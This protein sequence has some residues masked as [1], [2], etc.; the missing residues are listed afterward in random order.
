MFKM[1]YEANSHN[2]NC[3]IP[4]CRPLVN[5]KEM[6][7]LDDCTVKHKSIT[8]TELM[9]DAVNAAFNVIDP[10]CCL[11]S[12]VLIICGGGNNGG[13]GYALASLLLKS[14]VNIYIYSVA[15]KISSDDTMLYRN[16]ALDNDVIELTYDELCLNLSSMSLVIDA[17][18]G[19]GF[20]GDLSEKIVK[21]FEKINICDALK[22]SIDVPSG[23]VC[24]T[25]EV[26][27]GAF[28]ADITITFEFLKPCL[29]SYPAKAFCGDV[30]VVDIGFPRSVCEGIK[31]NGIILDENIMLP[32]K[33]KRN[34]NSNK[35]DFG[36]VLMA[37]GSKGMLGAPFFAA[38][39]ALRSGIGL[40]YVACDEELLL[41]LQLKLSEPVFLPY[42]NDIKNIG[43][44]SK[45]DVVLHG[46]G[47]GQDC[48]DNTEYIIQ[49]CSSVLVLDAD[50]LNTIANHPELLKEIKCPTILTPHPG[51]MARLLGVTVAD[52]QSNRI[53]NAIEY[54]KNTGCYVV[55]K[56]AATVI[57]APDGRYAV[58]STGNPGM[59]KGGSGDVLAGMISAYCAK[60][61]NI[62]TAV[63][64]AVYEH[65]AAADRCLLN[66][67]ERSML[68]SDIINYIK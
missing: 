20:H 48:T 31:S 35:G 54:A 27:E 39:G 38:M 11:D 43:D 4:P 65:G 64:A 10:M 36:K 44:L 28:M 26:A 40:L 14:R 2:N 51:E 19:T 18:Y 63:C 9:A 55:L 33:T 1:R 37:C 34:L 52:V 13:D 66:M 67:S 45:F 8:T 46:C 58:N 16:I 50:A 68:P 23:V 32:L 17:V 29:V 42:H 30:R 15:E 59:A 56:G 21:V 60:S 47:C 7:R 49:E 41:P 5:R 61:D 6:S 62:F 22:V 57:A 25:A 53:N 3:E 12:K 24:D